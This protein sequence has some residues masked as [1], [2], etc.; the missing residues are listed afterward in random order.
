VEP[1]EP[2]DE[3]VD[4]VDERDRVVG[5]VPRREIRARN[6]LHRCT[7]ILVR[8]TDGRINVHRRSETKDVD[9][10]LYDMLPGGVCA[11]GETYDTCARRE[12]E[13]ELAI[14]GVEP[15]P[16]LRHRYSG[17]EGE[18]W[19]AVYE[20]I[21]DGPIRMQASEVVWNDWVTPQELET[22]LHELPFCADSVEIYRRWSPT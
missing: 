4:V 20:V 19:G 22:M 6:L 18:A 11:A 12:L 9:P 10:G 13:E 15:R 7:Y 3:P 21:W 8:R 5:T 1:T 2:G 17:P 14:E 16:V